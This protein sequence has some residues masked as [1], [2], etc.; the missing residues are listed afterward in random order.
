MN[1]TRNM[2]DKC[3]ELMFYHVI[4]T[5]SDGKKYDGIIED[6]DDCEITVLI[7]ESIMPDEY[8]SRNSRQ[9]YPRMYR[10][11]IR[12]RFPLGGLVGL[13]LLGYPVF[14]GFYPPFY[15]Y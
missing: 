13:G 2:Y 3:K 4:L 15:P 14:G 1:N 5:M 10:R 8:E 6:V 11:F 12:R 9:P 7:G